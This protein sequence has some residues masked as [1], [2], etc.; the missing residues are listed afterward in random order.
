M[1]FAESFGQI[2]KKHDAETAGDTIERVIG[3]GKRVDVGELEMNVGEI[4]LAGALLGDLQWLCRDVSGSDVAGAIQSGGD[5]DGGFA[6]AASDVE[7]AE[8]GNDGGGSGDG[9]GHAAAHEAGGL[10]PALGGIGAC[11]VVPVGGCHPFDCS[12]ATELGEER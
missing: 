11:K 9:V 3:E 5:G 10:A 1:N 2:G 7:D 8:M 12:H 6:G 4:A